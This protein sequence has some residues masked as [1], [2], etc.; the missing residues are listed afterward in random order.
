MVQLTTTDTSANGY[1]TAYGNGTRPTASNVKFVA[2]QT[3]STRAIVPVA[4]DGSINV[5]NYAG[6]TDVIVDV[7]GSFSGP[8]GLASAGSLFTPINPERVIDTRDGTNGVAQGASTTV[9]I[10]GAAGIPALAN[11][12]PVAA[13]LNVTEA[14]DTAPGYLS[15]TPSPSSTPVTSD[16]N[17][18]YVPEIR[19][20]AD[21]AALDR[22]GAVSVYNYSGQTQ[23]VVDAFGYFSAVHAPPPVPRPLSVTTTSFPDGVVGQAYPPTSL[24]AAGGSPPYQWSVAAGSALPPG[25]SLWATGAISGTPSTVGRFGVTVAVTDSAGASI[26]ATL[27]ITVRPSSMTPAQLAVVAGRNRTPAPGPATATPVQ[28]NAVAV[29]QVGNVYIADGSNH[30]VEKVTPAG[31]L[32]IVAG[33]AGRPGPPTPGPAT[34]SRLFDPEGV[35]VDPAG[36]LYIGD[37]ANRVVERVTP[38]GI[39]SIA[40]GTGTVGPPTPGPATASRL[41]GSN[42]DPGGIAV[43]GAGNS[44]SPTAPTTWW[45]R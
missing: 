11:G 6:I 35:A 23:V 2:A 18:S 44:T 1:L 21:I 29:D 33:T 30:V 12:G 5:F 26:T 34:A 45:R 42:R 16:V 15:V 41:G 20:N 28:P 14:A 39:L 37:M 10:A 31:I 25:L 24:A 22:S 27:A 36:N 40:A 3:T 38:G 19:A 32:S 4:P 7:V 13:A 9:A 8:S 17:F 43:D